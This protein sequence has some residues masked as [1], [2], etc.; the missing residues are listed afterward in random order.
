MFV[1]YIGDMKFEKIHYL[2]T[3]HYVRGEFFPLTLQFE[4]SE[5]CRIQSYKHFTGSDTEFLFLKRVT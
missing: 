2:S 4:N 1:N 5:N 3:I